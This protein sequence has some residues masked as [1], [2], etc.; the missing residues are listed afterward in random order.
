MKAKKER[1]KI[2]YKINAKIKIKG[3]IGCHC[4][5]NI[6]L[7]TWSGAVKKKLRN[8]VIMSWMELMLYSVLQTALT[9]NL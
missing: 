6:S 1:Y 3:K 7:T 2:L 5:D 9:N 4:Q 8:S